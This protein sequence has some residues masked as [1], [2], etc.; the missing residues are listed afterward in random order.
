LTSQDPSVVI[1]EDGAAPQIVEPA[2]NRSDE[3]IGEAESET[4]EGGD[5][6]A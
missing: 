2:E 4:G 3:D 5:S 6:R 1:R